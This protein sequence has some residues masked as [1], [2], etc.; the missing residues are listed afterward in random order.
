[1]YL[2]QIIYLFAPAG[3]A[4]MIPPFAAK[5]LPQFNTPIDLGLTIRGKRIFGDHKTIRG[6]LFGSLAAVLTLA[7][8]KQ[9]YPSPFF[10]RLS[11]IDYSTIPFMFGLSL[12]LGALF[13]DAI[14]SFFKRQSGLTPGTTWFPWDQIDWIIGSLITALPFIKINLNMVISYLI[15]G[16]VSHL[17]GRVVGFMLKISDS[18]I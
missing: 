7:L 13:G 9:L 18:A 17:M 12:G 14:K 10:Y 8:Q 1:M 3:F 16:L 11:L 15:I 6:L 2:L 4:N 5:Y